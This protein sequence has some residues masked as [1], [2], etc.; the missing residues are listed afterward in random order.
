MKKPGVISVEDLAI[1]TKQAQTVRAHCI[2]VV[3]DDKDVCQLSVDL[4][5]DSGYEVDAASDGAAGWKAVRA[6]R[7]DLIITDNFMPRMTGLE[8]IEKIRDARMSLPVIMATRSLPTEQFY[9][10]PWLR[11]DA[12]LE[13]PCSNDV[14]LFTVKKLLRAEDSYRAQMKMLLPEYLR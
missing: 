11:P 14:F 3:D 7:Y 5:V 12:A 9:R 6:A 13:R 2:L 4:L 1:T 10:K 8:M